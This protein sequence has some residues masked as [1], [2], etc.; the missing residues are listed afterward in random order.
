M[1]GLLPLVTSFAERRLRLG[2]RRATLRVD[3]N[4]GAAGARFRGHEFHY[5]T[6]IRESSAEPLFS[7]LDAANE[8]LGSYGLR[9]RS[10]FGSFIHL[11]D[12]EIASS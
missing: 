6:V 4:F 10:V 5:A 2:Y 3:T 11:I 8:D 1:S 12:R 7:V 9:Q